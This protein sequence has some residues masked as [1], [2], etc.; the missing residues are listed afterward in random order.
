MS[1]KD[2]IN[3]KLDL[4]K[5]INKVSYDLD[6]DY[7][8]KKYFFDYYTNIF[9]EVLE[10]Y[11]HY[12]FIK[13]SFFLNKNIKN[14]EI[15]DKSWWKIEFFINVL[16]SN[17]TFKIYWVIDNNWILYLNLDLSLNNIW[18]L[19]YKKVLDC[20]LPTLKDLI[21]IIDWKSLKYFIDNWD[22]YLLRRRTIDF[23]KQYPQNI[24]SLY[25]IN[26]Y[27]KLSIYLSVLLS[28]Y[29]P[30]S[31]IYDFIE[32]WKD[33]IYSFNKYNWFIKYIELISY[34]LNNYYY[35]TFYIKTVVEFKEKIEQSFYKT[36]LSYKDFQWNS[37]FMKI[38][39]KFL[40]KR[41][42]KKID[43]DGLAVYFHNYE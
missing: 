33:Y 29:Q 19:G 40:D 38:I 23:I 25:L 7:Y 26:D 28:I 11:I 42:K 5:Y 27:T 22:P 17:S 39:N 34:S 20:W 31:D 4:Y 12:L 13:S 8:D 3:W 2:L 10:A 32:K 14:I 9:D 43:F 16:I 41:D 30:Q 18:L 37:E 21:K 15:L 36:K 1:L 35:D 24:D 6:I